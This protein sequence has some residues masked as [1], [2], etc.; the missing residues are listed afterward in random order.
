METEYQIIPIFP[1]PLYTNKIPEQ[2]VL[3]HIE[4]LD[5]EKLKSK[6]ELGG[7]TIEKY[8]TRSQNSY[9]LNQLS[10]QNLSTYI[11]QHTVNYAENYL[12]YDYQHYK[13]SQSWI[14]VK[15]PNQEHANHFHSNSLISG[16][17]FFGKQTLDS[18]KITFHRDDDYAHYYNNHQYKVPNNDF[19]YLAYDVN[20]IPNLLVIFP[21][22][23][24]HSVSKNLTNI[25]RKSLAFNIVPRDGFGS[26][27]TLNELKF[28]N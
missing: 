9:I 2:L 27:E 21:S 7:D 11:L 25:P 10:Y 5:N 24:R 20:Y 1:I 18:S 15:Y 28:N 13:F 12:R 22:T 16:V 6:P 23:L 3:D 19:S 14:S 17:L 4:L 8:G 26:E